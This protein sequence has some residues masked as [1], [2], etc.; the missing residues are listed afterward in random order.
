MITITTIEIQEGVEAQFVDNVL[1]FSVDET[2]FKLTAAEALELA[3]LIYKEFR[4]EPVVRVENHKVLVKPKQQ[5]SSVSDGR[6]LPSSEDLS[7]RTASIAPGLKEKIESTDPN[8]AYSH[9][10][11]SPDGRQAI[12]EIGVTDLGKAASE[13]GKA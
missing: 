10:G 4:S 8:L 2:D 7:K 9:T 11:R 6:S 13:L 12:I 3:D 5:V 1:Y